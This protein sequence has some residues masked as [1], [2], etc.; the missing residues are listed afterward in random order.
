M[1][2]EPF[3]NSCFSVLLCRNVKV[4]RDKT[5]FRDI[6]KILEFFDNKTVEVPVTIQSK[7]DCL[8]K[9]CV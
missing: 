1:I 4:R 8:T 2:T 7:I 5:L 3:I 9:I 6:L